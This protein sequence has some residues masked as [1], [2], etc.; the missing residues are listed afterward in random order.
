MMQVLCLPSAP[1]N[2]MAAWQRYARKT[3]AKRNRA[4][5]KIAFNER[6]HIYSTTQVSDRLF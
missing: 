4:R 2:S 3:P 5:V 1:E 6:I